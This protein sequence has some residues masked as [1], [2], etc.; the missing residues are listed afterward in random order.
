MPSTNGLERLG[1]MLAG[2]TVI[3]TLVA[4][5]VVQNHIAARDPAAPGPLAASATTATH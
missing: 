4:F 1:Y 3:V 5:L 2:V